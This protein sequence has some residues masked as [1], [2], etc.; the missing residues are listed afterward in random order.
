MS[1]SLLHFAPV[2]FAFCSRERVLQRSKSALKI[3]S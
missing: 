2:A 3:G 1:R